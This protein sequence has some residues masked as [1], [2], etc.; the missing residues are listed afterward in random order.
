MFAI[1]GNFI[2]NQ[3]KE[4]EVVNPYKNYANFKNS[5]FFLFA[6]STGEDWNKVMYDCS[7]LAVDGCIEGTNCGSTWSFTYH[8]GI[9]LICTHVMLN[10]FILVII[11]Q[12]EK[13]YLPQ[14]NMIS[15]FK[16][17]QARFM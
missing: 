11:Q 3:V 2:F 6:L 15:L 13:Y 9:V 4:G 16:S 7:R 17:D 14:D 5:F 1:L 12:F 10:L 8:M